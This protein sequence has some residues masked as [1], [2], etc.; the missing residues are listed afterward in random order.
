MGCLHTPLYH[1]LGSGLYH[2]AAE[3]SGSEAGVG[4]SDSDIPALWRCA[5][6]VLRSCG[7]AEKAA[8][9]HGADGQAGKKESGA[10][11]RSD[12]ATA[13]K[14]PDSGQPEQL[15][16]R[17]CGDAGMGRY[18]FGLFPGRPA[19]LE[20]SFGRSG[21][22]RAFYLSGILYSGRGRNVECGAC[23]FRAQGKGGRGGTSDL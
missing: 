14:R 21:E 4:D 12:T 16:I 9:Q 8:G 6:F 23:H 15:Y 13:G 11:G 7:C 5:V 3:Q 1:F 10:G 18:R 22:G 2:M 20:K 19:L 17:L